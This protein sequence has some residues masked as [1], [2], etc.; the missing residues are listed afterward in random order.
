MKGKYAAKAA[1]HQSVQSRDAEIEAYK[2]A[3]R[4]LTSERDDA[5]ATLA[6]A[7]QDHAKAL[8]AVTAQREEGTSPKVEALQIMLAKV[9]SERDSHKRAATRQLEQEGRTWKAMVRYFVSIGINGGTAWDIV[10]SWING[11][12]TVTEADTQAPFR[13]LSPERLAAL[14]AAQ[15]GGATPRE[16]ASLGQREPIVGRDALD[17]IRRGLGK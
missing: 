10:E 6:S 2:N 14:K 7:R 12:P 8:R 1:L 13:R 9:Q 11:R 5:R 16:S 4:R 3:V 15:R 17:I